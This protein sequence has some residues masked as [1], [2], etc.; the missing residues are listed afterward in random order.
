MNSCPIVSASRGHAHTP[1]RNGYFYVQNIL[2]QPLPSSKLKLAL[3]RYPGEPHIFK[4]SE[5]LKFQRVV[6]LLFSLSLR[7]LFP[8]CEL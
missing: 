5:F 7:I 2:T 6:I 8:F 4:A 3:T 1:E